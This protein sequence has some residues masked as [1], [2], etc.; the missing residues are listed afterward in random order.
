MKPLT[1]LIFSGDRFNIDDLLTDII[2]LNQSNLNVR[3]VEWSEDKKILKIKRKIY[4][5]FKIKNFK[6]YFQK[7]NWEYKYSKFIN[8]FKS[9]YILLLGDDDR[10]NVSNFKKIYK[11]L[12]QNYSGITISFSNFKTKKGFKEK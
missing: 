11:Y 12:N 7:G 3:V 4:N 2:K 9:K 5:S 8:K 6:V 1:I 10:I